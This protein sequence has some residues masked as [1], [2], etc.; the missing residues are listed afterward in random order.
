MLRPIRS[1]VIRVEEYQL[2]VINKF[3][4]ME[5]VTGEKILILS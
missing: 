2:I 3:P 1:W 5:K 4:G